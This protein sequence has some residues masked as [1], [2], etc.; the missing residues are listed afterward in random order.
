MKN[1]LKLV[2][3]AAVA[4]LFASSALLPMSASALEGM[5]DGSIRQFASKWSVVE[6][7]CSTFTCVSVTPA[8][9]GHWVVWKV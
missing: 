6:H 2:K 3:T 4:A 9:G 1:T 8:N 7:L 5:D